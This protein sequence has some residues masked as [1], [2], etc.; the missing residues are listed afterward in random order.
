MKDAAILIGLAF[1]AIALWSV[2]GWLAFAGGAR[3]RRGTAG[4]RWAIAAGL[5]F[6]PAAIAK[7]VMVLLAL[8]QELVMGGVLN[9]GLP[10]IWIF[11]WWE[12]ALPWAVL[13]FTAG[14][15]ALALAGRAALAAA[16]IAEPTAEPIAEP[17]AM[18]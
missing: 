2:I 18:R 14:L 15:A 3:W 17:A 4:G 13:A 12:A 11:E 10:D 9:H 1:V 6:A 8:W 5:L 7:T 16:V